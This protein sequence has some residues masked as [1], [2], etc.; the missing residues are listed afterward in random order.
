VVHSYTCS[1]SFPSPHVNRTDVGLTS[2]G[3]N[4]GGG[5]VTEMR[6]SFRAN[7]HSLGIIQH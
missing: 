3:E 6:C 4:S 2:S 5:V 1:K 7:L